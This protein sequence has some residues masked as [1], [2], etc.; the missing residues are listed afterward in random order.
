VQRFEKIEMVTWTNGKRVA[1]GGSFGKNDA[2]EAGV[3]ANCF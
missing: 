2:N 1:K 3:A